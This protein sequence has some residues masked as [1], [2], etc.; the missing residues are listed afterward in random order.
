MYMGVSSIADRTEIMGHHI[1][2]EGSCLT[3]LATQ[4]GWAA[5]SQS[6]WPEPTS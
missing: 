1:S 6:A 2:I 3:M 4:R 5:W